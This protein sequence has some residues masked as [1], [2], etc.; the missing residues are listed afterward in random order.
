MRCGWTSRRLVRLPESSLPSLGAPFPEA[1]RRGLPIHHAHAELQRATSR[2]PPDSLSPSHT[3]LGFCE[4]NTFV[5][6]LKQI[7]LTYSSVPRERPQWSQ[8]QFTRPQMV[9]RRCPSLHPRVPAA[10]VGASSQC[11]LLGLRAQPPRLRLSPSR[12]RSLA[13]FFRECEY[14]F[15]LLAFPRAQLSVM[16]EQTATG[17]VILN[18]HELVM[19]SAASFT[20]TEPEMLLCKVKYFLFLSSC[21]ISLS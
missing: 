16:S 15:T 10:A 5:K 12:G 2:R 13:F 21:L 3:P 9:P 18:F 14:L 20:L 11:A 6:R 1:V 7:V 4:E 8:S 19:T 17:L